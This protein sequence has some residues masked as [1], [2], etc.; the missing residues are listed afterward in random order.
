MSLH[1]RAAITLLIVTIGCYSMPSHAGAPPRSSALTE[2]YTFKNLVGDI[3]KDIREI[4]KFI[5]NSDKYTR[6]G[7]R[8]PKGILLSV[9]LERVKLQLLA[10]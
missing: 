6:M 10:P 8:M 1:T 3:P 2:T 9:L 7:A 5:E 4:T